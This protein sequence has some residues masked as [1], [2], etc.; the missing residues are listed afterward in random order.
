MLT[1]RGKVRERANETPQLPI[2][3]EDIQSS[4][5]KPVSGTV[6]DDIK[7]EK[8]ASGEMNEDKRNEY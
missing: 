7:E 5:F 4:I 8:D 1:G 2:R 6:L 3:A